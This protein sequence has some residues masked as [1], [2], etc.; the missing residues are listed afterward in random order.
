MFDLLEGAVV[1][2]V[3]GASKYRNKDDNKCCTTTETR[4]THDKPQ[5][6]IKLGRC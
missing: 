3:T 1:V 4:G 5:Q 2:V 6:T